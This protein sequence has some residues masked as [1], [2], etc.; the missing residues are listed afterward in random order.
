MPRTKKTKKTKFGVMCVIFAEAGGERKFLLLHRVLKWSG[1][2]FVKGGIDKG[3]TAEEAGKREIREEAGLSR[4]ELVKALEGKNE[5]QAKGVRY[6]YSVLLFR[7]D[8]DEEVK[9]QASPVKEHDAF[10][11]VPERRVRKM[12]KY[13]NTK[14]VFDLAVGELQ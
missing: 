7:S 14:R 3:E 9:L 2:E 12:L 8:G 6:S 11:W 1:W 13:E 5:W 10:E 4:V